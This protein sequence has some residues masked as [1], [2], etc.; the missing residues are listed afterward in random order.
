MCACLQDGTV[1]R[2][3]EPS[4]FARSQYVQDLVGLH[5]EQMCE[6]SLWIMPD[7][8]YNDDA[9]PTTPSDIGQLNP[10]AS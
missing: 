1:T 10:F 4:S 3:G 2:R 9:I 7:V 6:R 5:D 8:A